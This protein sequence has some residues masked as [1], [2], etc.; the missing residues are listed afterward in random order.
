MKV[1]TASAVAATTKTWTRRAM[2]GCFALSAVA[3]AITGCGGS[4][5]DNGGTDTR[6]VTFTG[7]VIDINNS[8]KPID[9]VV[10][11]LN[12]ASATTGV[13]GTFALKCSAFT[14]SKSG[15][16][17]APKAANGSDRFYRSGY[18]GGELYDFVSDGFPAM[19]I[20]ASETRTLGT[21]KLGNTDGPPFPP[22]I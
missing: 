5:N 7:K 1:E 21:F 12:G 8:D 4:S 9:G 22:K 2:L 14:T 19:S 20:Q 10:V 3:M 18:L 15:Y 17:A 13:D 6:L 16:L 11:T